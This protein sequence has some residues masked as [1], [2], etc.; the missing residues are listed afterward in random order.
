[1]PPSLA[2]PRHATRRS[3]VPLLVLS[4]GLSACDDAGLGGVDASLSLPDAQEDAHVDASVT[5]PNFTLRFRAKAGDAYFGCGEPRA[6]FGVDGLSTAQLLD[7]RFYVHDVALEGP[8]GELTPVELLDESPWQALGV[9]LLDFED[10][11]GACS[12]GTAPTRDFIAGV[13]PEGEYTAIRFTLGVPFELNHLDVTLA[14]S[15]LNLTRLYWNWRGGYVFLRADLQTVPE[16]DDLPAGFHMHLGSTGCTSEAANV[17]PEDECASPN[18]PTIRL[19]GFD[20][21]RSVVTLDVAAMLEGVDLAFNTEGTALGC[22][23]APTD[24]ECLLP[25][26]R[27]GLPFGD[28][29]P[30]MT[31]FRLEVE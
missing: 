1:M 14:P 29:E 28:A 3:L 30:L 17:A 20:P 7:L 11:T 27:L 12:N 24:P 5:A 19:D 16:G 6:A 2:G 18:R 26:T 10:A 15:P 25:M 8:A 31:A 13:A 21:K 22:M 9:A 4:L 23:S